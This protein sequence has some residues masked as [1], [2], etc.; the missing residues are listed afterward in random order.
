MQRNTQSI[1]NRPKQYR[2]ISNNRYL[3]KHSN[4]DLSDLLESEHVLW[5]RAEFE[6]FPTVRRQSKRNLFS[7]RLRPKINT[8]AKNNFVPWEIYKCKHTLV[9]LRSKK[10]KIIIADLITKQAT[11][12]Y[13]GNKYS[14]KTI[15]RTS[16]NRFRMKILWIQE[17]YIWWQTPVLTIQCTK[18]VSGWLKGLKPYKLNKVKRVTYHAN[19]SL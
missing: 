2:K 5:K 3:T 18:N 7:C 8:R 4:R 11:S 1:L 17:T 6:H 14:C 9:D 13:R 15:V 12:V 19:H 16:S 10:T